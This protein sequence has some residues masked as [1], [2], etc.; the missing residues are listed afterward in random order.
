MLMAGT[1]TA[2]AVVVADDSSQ[3]VP[4]NPV[5]QVHDDRMVHVPPF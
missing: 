1:V 5:G 3:S 4:V 2:E